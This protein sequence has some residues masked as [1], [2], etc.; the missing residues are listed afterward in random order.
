MTAPPHP[1]PLAGFPA[2]LVDRLARHVLRTRPRVYG[3]SGVQGSGKSTLTA[4]LAAA[5]SAHGLHCATLS[6]D[7]VYLDQP[8]RAHLAQTVHPLLVTRGPPG[9]HDVTLA[10]QTIDALRRGQPV[11][12]PRFDKLTDR[13]L[14]RTAWPRVAAADVLL[15]EGW[16][17]GA[18]PQPAA[19][20]ATPCNALERDHDPDGRW[21]HW[22]NRALARDYPALWALLDDWLLLTAPGFDVVA[23]WRWEQEVAAR[24]CRPDAAGMTQA[25]V[26]RFVQHFERVSRH[27]LLTLPRHAPKVI[28]LDAQRRVLA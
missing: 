4:Q 3:I 8:A 21:C 22:C 1:P 10:C 25:Q 17:L 2:S 11:R 14:A 13:R 12:L 16:C 28:G 15:L 20:L 6:L 5:L 26:M 24:A 19:A 27:A 23:R 18:L 9:T 7:D